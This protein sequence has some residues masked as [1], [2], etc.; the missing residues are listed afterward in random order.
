MKTFFYYN[1]NSTL[2]DATKLKRLACDVAMVSPFH[3]ATCSRTVTMGSNRWVGLG[4]SELKV[5]VIQGAFTGLELCGSGVQ[6]TGVPRSP[7]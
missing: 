2:L 4:H 7:N 3:L 6:G 1:K 5:Q